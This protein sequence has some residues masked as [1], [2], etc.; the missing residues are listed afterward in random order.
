MVSDLAVDSEG[1][2][3]RHV[4]RDENGNLYLTSRLTGNRHYVPQT[5]DTIV[6]SGQT[7]PFTGEPIY[8]ERASYAMGRDD[9]NDSTG[10]GPH[11]G[12]AGGFSHMDNMSCISCHS[13]W[14]NTCIGC[15]LEGEYEGGNFSN[16]TGERIVFNENNADFVYQTP[17]HFQLGIDAH[18]KISP[19][20]PNTETFFRW[21]D[22]N[23]NISRTMAFSDRNQKGNNTA[24]ATYPSL[25][26]NVLMPHS[27]RGRVRDDREG[28]RYCVSCHLT[29]DSIANYGAEYAE[30]R[31]AM[32]TDNFD[33]LQTG[34][35][36]FDLLRDHFGTNT[37]NQMNSP[38]WVHMVAGLGSGL[39]LFD[40]NG[41]PINPLDDNPDRVYC[42]D[43]SPQ[44]KGFDPARV[45]YNLDRIVNEAGQ[46]AS[47]N[48][49]ILLDTSGP[50][51]RDGADDPTMS[52][53]LGATLIERLTDPV[54]GIVLDTWLDA[55]GELQG[56]PANYGSGATATS[57]DD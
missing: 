30:F 52:G 47:S 26:H 36:S 46:S 10:L 14:T 44:T 48:N 19:I 39:F 40:E 1:N 51:L 29:Q 25:S 4:K 56:D 15:H 43:E 35:L 38:L 57:S 24:Q 53:P 22:Q 54:T 8:S 3:L 33:G 20:T 11:Q 17:V 42:E 2:P 31:A 32:S 18:N 5:L 23:D 6:D 12:A 9:G 7:N 37:G 49:H 45:R 27:I 16:I 55:N 50:N 21:I 34:L 28:A 13:A 41:C